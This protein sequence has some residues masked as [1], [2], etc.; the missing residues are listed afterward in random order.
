MNFSRLFST[1]AQ[2]ARNLTCLQVFFSRLLTFRCKNI[3]DQN[4]R[5][6]LL[7]NNS[8]KRRRIC[9]LFWSIVEMM[10]LQN[11]AL[12]CRKRGETFKS[13]W[14]CY[15]HVCSLRGW[16]QHSHPLLHG[17]ASCTM[18]RD[19]SDPVAHNLGRSKVHSFRSEL[20]WTC[21][22]WHD[23]VCFLKLEWRTLK[24]VGCVFTIS[25]YACWIKFIDSTSCLQQTCFF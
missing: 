17:F 3:I 25:T 20:H 24:Q 7:F 12:V 14:S 19:A 21:L 1:K 16:K 4:K 18:T 5:H 2:V 22:Q 9:R 10:F 23:Q 11:C 15:T 8:L 6:V 13:S